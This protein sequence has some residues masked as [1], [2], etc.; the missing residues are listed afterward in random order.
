MKRLI[1]STLILSASIPSWAGRGAEGFNDFFVSRLNCAL[2][3]DLPDSS[4]IYR[5]GDGTIT[6]SLESNNDKFVYEGLC[7]PVAAANVMYPLCHKKI[8]S[9]VDAAR[10]GYFDDLTP[11]TRMSTLADGLNR[12]F[13]ENSR[14]CP[15]SGKWRSYQSDQGYKFLNH[16]ISNMRS[17]RSEYGKTPFIAVIKSLG[18]KGLHY[19]TVTDIFFTRTKWKSK[20]RKMKTSPSNDSHKKRPVNFKP[21]A[22]KEQELRNSTQFRKI[23]KS[24]ISYCR[25]KYNDGKYQKIYTCNDFLKLMRKANDSYGLKLYLSEYNYLLFR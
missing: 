9:P 7:G 22:Q 12:I 5:C 18:A 21:V 24:N 16:A 15:N 14:Y 10:L 6:M 4:S 2:T 17:R 25:V 20:V 3:K 19:V 13:E 1:L 8:F 11:G 23:T